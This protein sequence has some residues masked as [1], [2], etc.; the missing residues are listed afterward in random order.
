VALVAGIAQVTCDDLVARETLRTFVEVIDTVAGRASLQVRAGEGAL[1]DADVATR[2]AKVPGVELV[3]PVVTGTAFLTDESGE[4]LSV[5]GMDLADPRTSAVYDLKESQ[6]GLDDPKLFQRDAVVVTRALAQRQA[7]QL[8]QRFQVDTVRGRRDLVV[9]GL[10]DPQGLAKVYGGNL[11]LMDLANAQETFGESGMIHQLDIV[12]ARDADVEQTATAIAKFLPSGL[13]LQRPSQRKADLHKV[14]LSIQILLWAVGLIGM[15]GSFLIAFSS[16]STMYEARM[17]QLGVLRAI[18]V[19]TSAVWR[20]LVKESLLIGMV[21]VAIGIPVGLAISYVLLPMITEAAALNSK[22]ITPRGELMIQPISL[23]LAATMGIGTAV[24]AAAVPAWRATQAVIVDT[25]RA[26]GV[27]Q[28]APSARRSVLLQGGLWALAAI[29]TYSQMR[30]ANGNWGLLATA[31][32]TLTAATIARPLLVLLETPLLRV[33]RWLGGPTGMLAVKSVGHNRRRSALTVSMV[34]VGLAAV[35]WLWM[36]ADSFQASV[37]DA[38]S[39]AMRAD[40]VVSSAHIESGFLEAPV[41]EELIHELRAIPGI[42]AV[43][44]ERTVEWVFADGPISIDAYDPSYFTSGEFGQWPLLGRGQ[45]GMWSAVARGEAV[46]ISS[47]FERN[48]GLTVKD[49]LRL[50]GPQGARAFTIAGVI[51][52]FASARGTVQMSR[53]VYREGWNDRRITRAFIRLADGVAA[54]TIRTQILAR[55]GR[56]YSLRVLTTAEIVDYF[57]SQV[58]R[59]FAGLYILAGFVL[60]IV[61]AGM[62]DTLAAGVLERTRHLGSLRVV[63]VRRAAIRRMVFGEALSLCLVGLLVASI[64]GYLLGLLWIHGTLPALLGWVIDARPPWL[65]LGAVWGATMV[66]SMLAAAVPA[67]MASR[68]APAEA[69][70]YE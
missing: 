55:L 16:M 69:L 47:S 32:I 14:M 27:E 37:V 30:G 43:A 20:E 51:T 53:D 7:L 36:V 68:L 9:R 12:V 52:H 26:R 42:T 11:L 18:G 61:L 10:L 56:K 60:A 44:G 49:T 35:C 39:G 8:G 62:G 54:G 15:V 3:V 70:R 58:R 24:L 29:A 5:H 57:A 64:A 23:F 1:F 50:D 41:S 2:V 40:L 13:S 67:Q 65:L 21:S 4:L 19:R 31:A 28:A 34:G 38:V 59:G 33:F 48:L 6:N 25:V 46:A 63:G 22:L 17:W 45:P 66:V